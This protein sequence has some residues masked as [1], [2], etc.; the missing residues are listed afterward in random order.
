MTRPQTNQPPTPADNQ[1]PEVPESKGFVCPLLSIGQM[2]AAQMTFLHMA[3]DA[4]ETQR[5]ESKVAVAAADG[6]PV[7]GAE[8]PFIQIPMPEPFVVCLGTACAAYVPDLATCGLRADVATIRAIDYEHGMA[9]E[10]TEEGEGEG[11]SD[12]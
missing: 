2:I 12:G 6:T 10:E 1:G 5:R 3:R 4:Q 11:G 8:Q 7:Q 9:A